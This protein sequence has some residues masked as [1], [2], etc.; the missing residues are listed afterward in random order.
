M[1]KCCQCIVGIRMQWE[2]DV[3]KKNTIQFDRQLYLPNN[4][5][6]EKSHG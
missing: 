5:P 6:W 1:A 2:V 3:V 4:P